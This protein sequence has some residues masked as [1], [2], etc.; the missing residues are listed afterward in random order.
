MASPPQPS[1]MNTGKGVVV[2]CGI[3]VHGNRTECVFPVTY[4]GSGLGPANICQTAVFGFEAN[5]MPQIMDCMGEDAYI[6]FINGEGMDDGCI[7]FRIDYASTANPGTRTG[8]ALPPQDGLLIVFYSDPADLAPTDRV[9]AAKNFIP[10][11]SKD[12]WV[13]GALD[14]ALV[15]NGQTLAD[16]LQNGFQDVSL[17]YTF[18]RV[19]Q[20][21][22]PHAPDQPIRRVLGQLPR[23]YM[24]IQRKRILPH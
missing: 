15:A 13:D 2:S 11:M 3:V 14:S 24:G 18:Y 6:S 20:P 9:S 7:P 19:I 8:K 5:V 23:F 16:T 4:D 22:R 10:G 12:D 21:K 17:A 1:G